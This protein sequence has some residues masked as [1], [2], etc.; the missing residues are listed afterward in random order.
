M[1]ISYY[2]FEICNINIIIYPQ[3]VKQFPDAKWAYTKWVN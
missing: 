2:Y 3:I 1:K